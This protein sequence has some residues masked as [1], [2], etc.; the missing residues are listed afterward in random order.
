MFEF[1]PSQFGINNKK[2]K[3]GQ[4]LSLGRGSFLLSAQD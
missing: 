1:G 3:K 2:L 4:Q